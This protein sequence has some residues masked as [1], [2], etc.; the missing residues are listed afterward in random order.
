MY[1]PIYFRQQI[2][3]EE[4]QPHC[5]YQDSNGFT[6]PTDSGSEGDEDWFLTFLIYDF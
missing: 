3:S 4:C 6:I 2:K 5:E 1:I